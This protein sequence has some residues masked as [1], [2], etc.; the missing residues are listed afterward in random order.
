MLAQLREEGVLAGGSGNANVL[1]LMPPLNASD[2]DVVFF[3]KAFAQSLDKA[4][5]GQAA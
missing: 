5:A 2:E 4:L 3:A 1:R